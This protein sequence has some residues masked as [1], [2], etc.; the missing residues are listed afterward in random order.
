MAQ[1][2][3]HVTRPSRQ[4][5]LPITIKDILGVENLNRREYAQVEKGQK[6]KGHEDG[7][8]YS[9]IGGQR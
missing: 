3:G 1:A 9:T 8:W 7:Q 2:F 4:G 5:V 6:H